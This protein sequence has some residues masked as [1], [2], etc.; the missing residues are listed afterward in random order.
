MRI[1]NPLSFRTYSK[2]VWIALIVGLVFLSSACLFPTEPER[3][4]ETNE[5]GTPLIRELKVFAIPSESASFMLNPRPVGDQ[6]YVFGVEVTINALPE[7]GWE[8]VEWVGPVYDETDKNAKIAMTGSRTV[9]ARLQPIES[10]VVVPPT[11]IPV[12]TPDPTVV[13]RPTVVSPTPTPVREKCIDQGIADENHLFHGHAAGTSISVIVKDTQV[14]VA[15]AEGGTRDLSAPYVLAIPVCD[16]EGWSLVGENV[17]FK[18]DG[19]LSRQNV[20]LR[21][22]GLDKLDLFTTQIAPAK[23]PTPVPTPTV[24]YEPTATPPPV[25]TNRPGA[26][27]NVV[28]SYD[29]NGVRVSW[30]PPVHTGGSNIQNYTVA[31]FPSNLGLNAHGGS[32]SVLVPGSYLQSGIAY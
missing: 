16:G 3:P 27:T 10:L 31:I 32:T 24:S 12:P 21:A 28:A 7:E 20:S 23:R 9:V 25:L 5:D 29:P 11:P 14:V 1:G 2:A 4:Q 19:D 22:G 17:G 30:S 8:L 15:T 26:P 6:G 13:I 18:L